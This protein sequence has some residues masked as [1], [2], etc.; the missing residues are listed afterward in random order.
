E[1]RAVA[2]RHIACF[3]LIL[4]QDGN[5]MQGTRQPRRLKSRIQSLGFLDG[6]RVD[7]LNRIEVRSALVIG[8]DAFQVKF[9]QPAACDLAG[10]E[11]HVYTVDS[12][13]QN[14]ETSR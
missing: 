13:F 10:F 14:A 11:S 6:T 2:G 4:Q 7:R 12:C 3:D 9:Y 1:G 5:A 8:L